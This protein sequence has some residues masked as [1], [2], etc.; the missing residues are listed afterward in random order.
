[1]MAFDREQPPSTAG[2]A[3]GVE[4]MYYRAVRLTVRRPGAIIFEYTQRSHPMSAMSE[5]Q[6]RISEIAVNDS[7]LVRS[8]RD[9][10]ASHRWGMLTAASTLMAV[11]EHYEGDALEALLFTHAAI[12]DAMEMARPEG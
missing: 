11:A 10:Q 6:A 1:M 8:F 2:P 5:L 7:D 9:D 12:L 3:H 4:H